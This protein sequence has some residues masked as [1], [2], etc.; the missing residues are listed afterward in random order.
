MWD[1]GTVALEIPGSRVDAFCQHIFIAS[2]L[3]GGTLREA[4]LQA[5]HPPP[6]GLE[7]G[8]EPGTCTHLALDE[9]VVPLYLEHVARPAAHGAAGAVVAVTAGAVERRVL[10]GQL[11]AV[12]G[13]TCEVHT[14]GGGKQQEGKW[15]RS[16]PPHAGGKVKADASGTKPNASLFVFGDSTHFGGVQ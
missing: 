8:S 9:L 13:L 12:G 7:R 6:W 4:P 2:L 11:R 16:C 10:H 15:G 1:T 14:A 5:S 3:G